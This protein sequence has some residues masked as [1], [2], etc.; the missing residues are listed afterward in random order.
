[1]HK[2]TVSTIVLTV[3]I[4]KALTPFTTCP[5]VEKIEIRLTQSKL[6]LSHSGG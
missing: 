4:S 5:A 2:A 3:M 1:M 6:M